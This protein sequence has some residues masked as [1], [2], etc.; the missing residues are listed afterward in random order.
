MKQSVANPDGDAEMILAGLFRRRKARPAS[1]ELEVCLRLL[2]R[3]YH[4]VGRDIAYFE[5][6]AWVVKF[7]DLN[8]PA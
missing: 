8:R 6:G 3:L 7:P 1:R 4:S 2:A 5:V